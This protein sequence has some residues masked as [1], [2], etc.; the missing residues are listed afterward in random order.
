MDPYDGSIRVA[1]SRPTFD[2][3]VFSEHIDNSTWKELEQQNLFFLIALTKRNI[4]L[5]PFLN[6]LPLQQHLKHNLLIPIQCAIAKDLPCW[7]NVN[8]VAQEKWAWF[9]DCYRFLAYSCNIL[10]YELAKQ[11]DINTIA[12]YAHIFGLGQPTN[13]LF[14]ENTG[15]VPTREWKNKTNMNNGG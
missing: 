10:F 4:L 14:S 6:L 5:D 3:N 15:L 7:P 12:H 8:T 9:Y 11:L 2:P 1:L 13:T